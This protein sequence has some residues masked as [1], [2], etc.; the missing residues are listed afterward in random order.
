MGQSNLEQLVQNIMGLK[1]DEINSITIK[2][3]AK[4][5][6]YAD[7]K[8]YFKPNDVLAEEHAIAQVIRMYSK[9]AEHGIK[10]MP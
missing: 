8:I 7:V 6:F 1:R 9:L 3:T 10:A 2:Q 5:D 4:G